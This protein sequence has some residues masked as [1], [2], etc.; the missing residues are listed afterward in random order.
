MVIIGGG[1]TGLAAAH[2]LARTRPEIAVTLLEA[3]DRLG[4]VILTEE[5]D[6]FLLEGGPDSFLARKQEANDFWREVGVEGD[7]LPAQDIHGRVRILRDGRLRLLPDSFNLGMPSDVRSV[8]AASLIS[9]PGKLRLALERFVPRRR[10]PSDESLADFFR[11]RLGRE[12]YERIGEP[13]LGGIHAADAERLSLSA[14]FPDLYAME[15]EHGS[16]TRALKARRISNEGE[17]GLR[18][19]THRGGMGKIVQAIESHLGGIE[20]RTGVAC[21]EIQGKAPPFRVIPE[22]GDA[23]EA[24]A[25]IIATP[26]HAA[27]RI[28]KE[29]CPPLCSLLNQIAYVSTAAV[30]L[31]CHEKALKRPLEG[32]GFLVPRTEGKT[33]NACTFVS[34]KFIGRAPEDRILLRAF[35]GGALDPDVIQWPGERLVRRV[36]DELKEIVGLEG[37]PI[38]S[39][40]YRW[41]NALPQYNLGHRDRVHAIDKLV[42]GIPGLV[43]AGAAYKGTGIPDCIISGRLAAKRASR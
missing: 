24:D 19:V 30:Y 4:G 14:A 1:I 33:I 17:R 43:L 7:L 15:G 29:T 35:V 42:K 23:L 18:F 39:R 12:A 6:A 9:I 25:L 3:R 8:L 27:A 38:W 10:D 40:V 26:A 32:Y 28:L 37:E 2:T 22:N 36:R 31:A 41:E 5:E 13:L 11:R 21:K 34:N 20:V 16:I